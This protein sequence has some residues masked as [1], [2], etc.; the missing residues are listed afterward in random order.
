MIVLAD[1]DERSPSVKELAEFFR[2]I[3]EERAR[4]R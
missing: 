1:P 3:G 4:V 2:L